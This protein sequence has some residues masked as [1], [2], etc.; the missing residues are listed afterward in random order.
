MSES[1]I[2]QCPHC[3]TSFRV[4][5]AQLGAANGAVRCGTCLKVFNALQH[6][7]GGAPRANAPS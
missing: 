6:Q 5:D 1:V 2:T 7:V 3:S 4:N